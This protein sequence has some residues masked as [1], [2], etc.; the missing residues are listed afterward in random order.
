MDRRAAAQEE[1]IQVVDRTAPRHLLE[2]AIHR[3]DTTTANVLCSVTRHTHLTVRRLRRESPALRKKRKEGMLQ[4][5]LALD[6]KRV[7]V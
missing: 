1:V 5:G 3:R 2:V 7:M 4:Q 6:R